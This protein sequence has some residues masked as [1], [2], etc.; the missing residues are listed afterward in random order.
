MGGPEI[1]KA[2]RHVVPDCTAVNRVIDNVG[3]ELGPDVDTPS[4]L[5]TLRQRLEEELA[6]GQVP[7]SAV[8][9]S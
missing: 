3:Q 7:D 1:A 5:A 8:E 9:G 4:F 2:F 6:R